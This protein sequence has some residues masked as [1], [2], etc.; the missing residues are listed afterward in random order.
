MAVIK[1][2]VREI[3]ETSGV[4]NPFALATKTGLNY[5]ICYK[6]WN[7]DQQRIDLKTLAT[8]CEAFSLAPGIFFSISPK[9][10]KEE[11]ND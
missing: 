11:L 5:A 10:K 3:A 9:I 7:G 6:L 1:L 2:I 8:L 4:E